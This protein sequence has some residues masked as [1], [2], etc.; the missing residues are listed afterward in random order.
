MLCPAWFLALAVLCAGG[1]A[2]R[3][4]C[5]ENTRCRDLITEESI[6]VSYSIPFQFTKSNCAVDPLVIISGVCKGKYHH[7]NTLN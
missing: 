5:W 3:A 1:S 7:S 2:V 4:Q 6:L